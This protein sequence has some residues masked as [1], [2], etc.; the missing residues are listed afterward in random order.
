MLR[1]SF[2]RQTRSQTRA[3]EKH[4]ANLKNDGDP[5]EVSS[6]PSSEVN[7]VAD[8]IDDERADEKDCGACDGP[9]N[10]DKYMVQCDHCSRWYH[11]LC[12]GVNYRTVHSKPFLCVLCVP[13]LPAPPPTSVT[14]RS[15]TPSSRR[16]RVARE[17]QRLE[18][19]RVLQETIQ[20]ELLA[21]EKALNLR[22]NQE[23]LER[24]KQYIARKYQLL[25]QQEDADTS[26]LLS[27]R[28]KQSSRVKSWVKDQ[29]AAT[30]ILGSPT[31]GAEIDHTRDELMNYR[32]IVPCTSTPLQTVTHPA[33]TST[34]IDAKHPESNVG[35]TANTERNETVGSIA[36][37]EDEDSV[38]TVDV[39]G[40][41]Q[42]QRV[43]VQPFVDILND[44]KLKV[45][46]YGARPKTP[47]TLYG[48]WNM[49]TTELRKQRVQQQEAYEKEIEMRRR[50]ELDLVKKVNQLMEHEKQQYEL[51]RRREADLLRQ[52]RQRE[53][54]EVKYRE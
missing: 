37:G 46:Q 20:Q 7:F 19:E 33:H 21:A 23:K 34:E 42:I 48:K 40:L 14:G 24:E 27:V 52:L 10:A 44:S 49:E 47:L 51:Q 32:A 41:A 26:S 18:E 45:T 16:A 31:A 53:E 3:A 6:R 2:V 28:T 35:G 36:I 54:E 5:R 9:N 12:A 13:R 4:A 38:R 17:M 1:K 29:N 11:F 8:V 22:A 25:D 39:D 15:S 50:R 30:D 43:N